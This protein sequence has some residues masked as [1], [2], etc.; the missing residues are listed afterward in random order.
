MIKLDK[1]RLYSDLN[2]TYLQKH[3][4]SKEFFKHTNQ[5]QVYGGSHNL[6]LNDPFPLYDVRCLGPLVTTVDGHSHIDFWQGHFA[7]ILGHNPPIIREALQEFLQNGEGL[8][9]GFPGQYQSRL[10]E[11]ITRQTG[12][13]G[14]RFTTS[15]TLAAMYSIMLAKSYT[16]RELVL[17]I[18]GGWHGA[19]PYTLNGMPNLSKELEFMESAGLSNHSD[20]SFILTRFNDSEDLEDKFRLYGDRLA[21]FIIE[22]FMGAGGFL[23][24]QK[25]YLHKARELTH[26]YGVQLIFDEVLSGFRFHAGSLQT[27]YGINSDLTLFGKIIGGGMPVSAVAGRREI[28]EL[29]N[30]KISYPSKVKFNGGTFSAHPA[31]MFA[32]AVYLQ[33]LIENAE[34]LYPRIGR[35]GNKA[36]NEIE[37]IFR[38]HGFPVTCTGLDSD[39]I[40]ESSMVGV[41]FLQE[42]L[43]RI[44]SPEQVWSINKCDPEMR[45]KIFKLAMINEGVNICHGFGGVSSAHSDKHIQVSLDAVEHTART[46]LKYKI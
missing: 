12:T 44:I 3:K 41:H 8:V 15:G 7:N 28:L 24:A 20:S 9:T 14:I 13:E 35:L 4:K 39:V 21:C 23:F 30:P 38:H 37:N 19:Q 2:D 26:Q 22:P 43:D 46:F 45:E 10:A 6:R 31:S 18:G 40:S 5:F 17:K 34:S 42:N 33:Y 1:E 32:G 36:R 27:L 16:Q 29:C 25:E 11:L